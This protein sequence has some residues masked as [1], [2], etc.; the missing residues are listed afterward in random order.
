M[1]HGRGNTDKDYSVEWAKRTFGV[2]V[3]HDVADAIG[4]AVTGL[5]MESEGEMFREFS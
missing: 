1:A 2:D 3:G 5:R 4:I